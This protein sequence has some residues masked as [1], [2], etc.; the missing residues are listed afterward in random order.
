MKYNSRNRSR[1]HEDKIIYDLFKNTTISNQQD[2][3]SATIIL[4]TG[5]YVELGA[6]DGKDESNTMFFD[7]CLGW[8]GLLIEGQTQSYEKVIVNRPHAVKMS[9]S[10]TCK[11]E[12]E[13]VSFYDYPLSNNGMQDLAKSYIGKETIEIPC[14]P[15]TPV[16]L[17]IFGPDGHISFFSLD[18]EGAEL[19]VLETLNFDVLLIEVIMVE[20]QNAHCPEANCESVHNIRRHMAM[21]RKY[22]LFVD[23]LEASDVYIR[24]G[25]A[26]WS[27]AKAIERDRKERMERGILEH[28]ML[29]MQGRHEGPNR[30]NNT[31]RH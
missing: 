14:G 29:M 3:G 22:S 5:T 23:F 1:F 11:N 25:T 26:A 6:F 15:L 10:P 8:S 27:R 4:P 2:T 19:L 12:N 24:W 20:I 17:D 31:R 9:F 30:L 16:L 7:K 18:V 28:T 21:T 13:T